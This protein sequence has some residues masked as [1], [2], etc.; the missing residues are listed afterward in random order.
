DPTPLLARGG[1][2][3]AQRGPEP[4]RT[5]TDGQLR[6]LLQTPAPEIQQELAPAFRAFAKAVGHGQQLLAAI[7]IG[8][9]NHQDTLLFLSHPGF[10]VDAIGPDVEELP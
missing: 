2:D 1:E 8:P 7:F 10:E 6:I 3:L 5:V 4:E 9:D